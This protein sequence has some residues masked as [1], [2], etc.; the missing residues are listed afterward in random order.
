MT[1]N[2]RKERLSLAY[3][4]TIVGLAGFNLAS[5]ELDDDSVDFQVQASGDFDPSSPRLDIQLKA[6]T[7]AIRFR[8]GAMSWRVKRKNYNDLRRF[9]KVPRLLVVF[10]GEA[11][12]EA[13]FAQTGEEL[14]LRRAA[15]WTC[16]LGAPESNQEF[17]TV[18]IRRA[19]L[20]TP[21]ALRRL[22]LDSTWRPA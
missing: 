8:A 9:T 5:P 22:M 16:L 6:T 10:L 1:E 2:L 15:Y 20:L 3:V 21:P 7:K 11:E 12:D 19:Q 18:R 17:T 4:R 14:C 13:G